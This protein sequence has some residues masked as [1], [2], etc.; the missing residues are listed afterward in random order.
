MNIQAA[1]DALIKDRP[2]L[3][4]FKGETH[5]WRMQQSTLEWM[6]NNLK[7]DWNTLETG[8]GYT[9]TLF[10][11]SGCN[12]TTISPSAPEHIRISEWCSENAIDSSKI[13][14]IDEPSQDVLPY[15]DKTELDLVLI[16]GAHAFPF[17]YLDWYYTASRL[18]VGGYMIVDDLNIITGEHLFDFL[19]GE[20]HA[21]RWRLDAVINHT[22]IFVKT[23]ENIFGDEEWLSQPYLLDE[24]RKRAWKWTPKPLDKVKQFM[25]K[26]NFLYNKFSKYSKIGK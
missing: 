14:F 16:D 25:K 13:T 10:A 17:P 7:S 20:Y 5:N 24:S 18:R 22:A 19:K 3:N 15:M 23:S 26:S 9:T 1:L 2:S 11:A 8:A 6:A 12:H 21:G 4:V